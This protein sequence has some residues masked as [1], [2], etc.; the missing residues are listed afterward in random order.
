MR[1]VYSIFYKIDNV[2]QTATEANFEI[3]VNINVYIQ[4]LI[5]DCAE[6]AGDRE[7]VFDDT[8]GLTKNRIISIVKD[9]NRMEK[10]L[11]LAGRLTKVEHDS[12]EQHKNLK[13]K[14]PTG[15]LLVAYVDME[16]DG[17]NEYKA[18]LA[19]ADYTEFIEEVTGQK[20]T[21][22]P[23]KK[24]LFKSFIANVRWTDGVPELVNM[25]TYDP[26]KDKAQYWWDTFLELSEVRSDSEN[27]EN[28]MK[29]LRKGILNPIKEQHPEA[30][31]PLYNTT[32]RYMRARGDFDLEYFRDNVFGAQVINDHTFNMEKWKA[33]ITNLTKEEKRFDR[34]FTK[35]PEIIKE[36]S[37]STELELT[38]LIE[39]RIKKDFAARDK[40]I[41]PAKEHGDE[42]IFIKSEKGFKFANGLVE[43][44]HN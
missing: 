34:H 5:Q 41:R 2:A 11:E 44:Q 16:L 8:R 14:I 26:Q 7:Y 24:K 23:T 1:T 19:K 37:Y 9:E 25:K 28:A 3:P 30:Y 20:K 38:P 36:R 32:I 39:L 43:S 18:I 29:L 42:G 33:K 17:V 4:E 6:K 31:L 22:L 13:S 10:A 15:I 35:T 27:T 21:G 12:N 40:I